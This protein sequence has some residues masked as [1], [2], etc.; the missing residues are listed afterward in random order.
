MTEYVPAEQLAHAD[1]DEARENALYVPPGQAV[2]LAAPSEQ[3]PPAKQGKHVVAL[4]WTNRGWK[5]PAGQGVN[6]VALHQKPIGQG[7]HAD[8]PGDAET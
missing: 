8:A 1:T 3:N 7:R 2:T 6:A 5:V 4:N